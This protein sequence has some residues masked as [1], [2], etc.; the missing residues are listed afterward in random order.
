VVVVFITDLI[1]L[2]ERTRRKSLPQSDQDALQ[3]WASNEFKGQNLSLKLYDYTNEK[4]ESELYLQVT[5]GEGK[6]HRACT[7]LLYL[8]LNHHNEK[9]ILRNPKDINKIF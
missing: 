1:R 2:T 5:N 9:A 3:S 4:G 6:V 8:V 7:L